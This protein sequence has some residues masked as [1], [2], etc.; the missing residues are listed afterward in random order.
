MSREEEDEAWTKYLE[1]T[2]AGQI[3]R[4]LYEVQLRH[5]YQAMRDIG[6]VETQIHIVRNEDMKND[7][8]GEYRKI[9]DFLGLPYHPIKSTEARSG[10]QLHKSWLD[11]D[12]QDSGNAGD[13]FRSLQQT[14]YNM[15]GGD[16]DGYWDPTSDIITLFVFSYFSTRTWCA[17]YRYESSFNLF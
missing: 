10:E 4:S 12:E 17:H 7:L 16:W 5:W 9:L 3:G 1:L 8:D 15:L 2:T 6:R 13:V 11:H 14:L